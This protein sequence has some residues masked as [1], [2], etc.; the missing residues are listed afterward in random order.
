MSKENYVVSIH[1]ALTGITEDIEVSE[2]IYNGYRRS[3]W[4]IRRNDGR[5]RE[6]EIPFSD[7]KGGLD[8]AYENFDEFRS[9]QDDPEKIVIKAL[10]L[11]DLQHVFA[12]LTDSEQE[13][14]R[15]FYAEGKSVR[16]AAA[17]MGLPHM[18]VQSQKARL[19][20]K[21]KKLLEK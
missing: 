13:L 3:F 9:E 16:Q 14:L 18:T 5:F 7:L 1:N 15:A 4:T 10:A 6:N 20:R 2:A 21:L 17:D 11:Q 12:D 8:G 19:L